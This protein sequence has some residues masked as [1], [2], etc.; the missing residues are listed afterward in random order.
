[1]LRKISTGCFVGVVLLSNVL[2]AQDEKMPKT[3]AKAVW[4]HITETHPFEKWPFWPN[5]QGIYNSK[6]P[7]AP[8]H[9]IYVNKQALESTNPPL[10]NESMVIKYNLRPANEV[11]GVTIM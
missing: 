2:F 8:K 9:K 1:M 7:H 3:E 5:H 6:G 4:K 10:Q 11:K